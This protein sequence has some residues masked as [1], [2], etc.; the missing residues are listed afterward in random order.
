M[1]DLFPVFFGRRNSCNC[2][3]S[4]I[5]IIICGE[6][7]WFWLFP[8]LKIKFA[9]LSFFLVSL[10]WSLSF[11]SSDLTSF[12]LSFYWPIFHTLYFLFF[13]SVNSAPYPWLWCIR[14]VLRVFFSAK[15]VFS[16]FFIID[17]FCVI[18]LLVFLILSSSSSV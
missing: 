2:F 13:R 3:C 15:Y 11:D 1:D 9:F 18:S 12:Y 8:F 17:Y 10:L 14:Y 6:R 5:R 4:S 7:P 16:L